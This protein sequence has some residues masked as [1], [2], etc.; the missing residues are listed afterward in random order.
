MAATGRGVT[1]TE[2]RI[3]KPLLWAAGGLM[4]IIN[5]VAA[6][7]W[8]DDGGFVASVSG[9]LAV[10]VLLVPLV[11]IVYRDLRA[12]RTHM[13]ELVLL[14]VLA[15]CIRA[16]FTMSAAIALFMLL[17]MIIEMRTASGAQA[18]LTALAKLTPGKA[19]RLAAD[20]SETEVE[21]HA[22]RAG[23]RIRLRPGDSIL[24]DGVIVKGAGAVDEANITGESL[25]VDKAA[26]DT[27][28]AGT[29]NLSGVLEVTVTKAGEDTTLGR[30]R[31]LILNA[32][33][34]RLPFV[35]MIDEYVRYYTP[36]VLVGVA[37]VLFF[38]QRQ[39]DALDRVVALLVATCPIAMILAT[40]TAVV[41]SLAAAARLG[42]L[43][44][45]VNDVEALARVDAFVFDKT[46]T[47]TTGRLE[48]SRLTP[49]EGVDAAELLRAA[50]LAEQG[51]THPV[52]RAVR[53][54]AEK[55]GV[56]Q[57]VPE[58]LHEEPGRGVRA[59]HAGETVVA[60]NLAW[61]EANGVS[62]E[63]FPEMEAAAQLGLSLLFVLRGGKP[64]GWLGIS[65][66]VRDD[67]AA[68]LAGLK[69]LGVRVL[70]MVSGD[71]RQVVER[72]REVLAVTDARGECTPAEKVE[73][74][75]AVR[76][77]GHRV[78]FV[79]DGVNDGPALATSDIGVA[80]GAAGSDVALESATVA[81]MNNELNRLPFLVRLA[82]R[83]RATVVQNL[84]VGA[85]L[86]A[87]GVVLAAMGRLPPVL[88]AV[89]QVCGA[90]TVAMNSARLIRQGE[91]L[92]A[93]AEH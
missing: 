60:G 92:E 55:V 76:E 88:A 53:A 34:S 64:L 50:A 18:S 52:A 3:G 12:G 33:R 36:L 35:R 25:P 93:A 1:V 23:D 87:G 28:F 39:P 41:A 49:C 67:A 79:G 75:E 44:K 24:A 26:E 16:D 61:M 63:A 40:P 32:E 19:R 83:M 46:G 77:R 86:I 47:L 56:S 80:M 65:D 42:V 9:L 72:V 81:L 59:E 30:V 38:T 73:Y 17:A 21:S 37:T 43:V 66:H 84:V 5:A 2:S 78:V 69:G 90:L 62:E 20:G 89:L 31:E 6:G 11:A 91:E 70:A 8:I 4:L 22:L 82:Q 54:L 13:H 15:S 14:A 7:Q 85:V 68:A 57:E 51:S 29:M 48:V 58:T 74:I 45:D 27:V 71:R 10:A